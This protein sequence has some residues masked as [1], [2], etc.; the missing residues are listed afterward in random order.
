MALQPRGASHS[1][2]SVSVADQQ[3]EGSEA[4]QQ[5]LEDR[6][7]MWAELQ[8]RRSTEEEAAYW[9]TRAQDIERSRWWRIGA[10]VRLAK[11]ISADPPGTLQSIS[12]ELRLRRRKR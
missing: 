6:N 11:R 5:L 4:Y 1:G 2:A 8:E 10:P 12:H 3:T 7:R 9:R